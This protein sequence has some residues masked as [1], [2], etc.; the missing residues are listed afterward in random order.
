MTYIATIGVNKFYKLGDFSGKFT[1]AT[2]VI[3]IGLSYIR[4]NSDIINSISRI[5][6]KSRYY[7]VYD[8]IANNFDL[9]GKILVQI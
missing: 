7:I 5:T 2:T 6:R 1:L 4:V 8:I 3:F 9:N